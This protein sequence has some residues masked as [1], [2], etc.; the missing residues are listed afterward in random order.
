MYQRS[1]FA[2]QRGGQSRGGGQA[3]AEPVTCEEMLRLLPSADGATAGEEGGAW[4]AIA[5]A[6]EALTQRPEYAYKK[7]DVT[8]QAP[9]AVAV[10][11]AAEPA[12][13][14]RPKRAASG[15][16]T[17]RMVEDLLESVLTDFDPLTSLYNAA[18]RRRAGEELR[19]AL[20]EFGS[21]SEA[22][23][24]FGMTKTQ[25]ALSA[26]SGAKHPD[27]WAIRDVLAFVLDRDDIALPEGTPSAPP[28]SAKVA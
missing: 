25:A 9:R 19:K 14:V 23:F 15:F 4:Y 16:V 12:A 20:M 27:I 18:M 24:H 22:H 7:H 17:K 1:Q 26:L 21:S 2:P 11:A 6:Q 28:G 3:R 5:G 13:A 8:L 10:A